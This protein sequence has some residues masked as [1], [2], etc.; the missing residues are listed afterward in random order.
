MYVKRYFSIGS[1]R[2]NINW[3]IMLAGVEAGC[4]AF[5]IPTST[6]ASQY[7]PI[8][9][10][11][12][13]LQIVYLAARI[14]SIYILSYTVHGKNCGKCKDPKISCTTKTGSQLIKIPD[15]G[16]DDYKAFGII[17]VKDL[18]TDDVSADITRSQSAV[19]G[20]CE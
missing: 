11:L 18:F 19:E 15:K 7:W 13:V 14:F 3:L 5:A 2:L 6:L 4:L 17:D 16:K 20:D 1:R 9:I 10:C 8:T 12:I